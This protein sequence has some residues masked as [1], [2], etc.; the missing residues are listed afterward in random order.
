MSRDDIISHRKNKFLSIGRDK[1]FINSLENPS[2]LASKRKKFYQLYLTK[3][4][5]YSIIISIIIAIF[6]LFLF[7]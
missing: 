2:S 4:H 7:L 3:N 5:K 6:L 1:G